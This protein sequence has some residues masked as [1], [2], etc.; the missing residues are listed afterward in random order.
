M[1]FIFYL[2]LIF[3][4][5]RYNFSFIV[6]VVLNFK[7]NFFTLHRLDFIILLDW[8]SLL[9]LRI[10]LL[11]SS[12]VFLYSIYYIEGELNSLKFIYLVFIFV[13]SI[14][15]LILSPNIFGLI[16]GWDG[17]GLVSYCLV[18]FYYNIKSNL[19][20]LITVLTN[21]LGDIFILLRIIILIGF[22]LV[23]AAIKAAEKEK[24]IAFAGGTHINEAYD[25]LQKVD[26]W[27]PVTHNE[28]NAI[29][30]SI[31][32][33][34]NAP[35]NDKWLQNKPQPISIE[36]LEHYLKQ[37]SP[38]KIFGQICASWIAKDHHSNIPIF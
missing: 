31:A 20:S 7:L 26:N 38:I 9:F 29:K 19:S 16:L 18:I 24:I 28:I 17:L 10:V 27:E 2:S 6:G 37:W 25:L 23:D 21:R 36:L 32:R 12:I 13:L 11:I 1:F 35:I 30:S 34:I 8:I 14:C 22:K 4:S 5:L 3:F 33:G 15:L